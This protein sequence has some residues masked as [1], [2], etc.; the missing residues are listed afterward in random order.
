MFQSPRPTR[1]ATHNN[2][3]RPGVYRCFNPRVPRGTRQVEPVHVWVVVE[4][5][6]PRVPRGTRLNRIHLIEILINVSIPASHA[7]RDKIKAP[8]PYPPSEFQSPR[9]TRDATYMALSFKGLQRCFNPRVPRGT[10]LALIACVLAFIC[11]SIP[12]S[13]AGRD[14]GSHPQT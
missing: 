6:N 10:R 13:H 5:F 7:G 11:V 2:Q 4:S 9:P 14:N 8:L 12:A 1:D 3:H